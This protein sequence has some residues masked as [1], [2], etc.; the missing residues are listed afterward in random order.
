MNFSFNNFEPPS[1]L[2]SQHDPSLLPDDVFPE[3][4]L[5]NNDVAEPV[6][7]LMIYCSPPSVHSTPRS[8]LSSN[9][10]SNQP[11]SSPN[12]HSVPQKIIQKQSKRRKRNHSRVLKSVSVRYSKKPRKSVVNNAMDENLNRFVTEAQ[13]APPSP[14][15]HYLE[16][17]E[18]VMRNHSVRLFFS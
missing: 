5:P 17:D 11:M 12:N 13:T 16:A 8:T 1:T 2:P 10:L 7:Q 14:G 9:Y 6:S 18:S 15:H 3:S 4:E